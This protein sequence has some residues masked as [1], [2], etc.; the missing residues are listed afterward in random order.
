VTDVFLPLQFEVEVYIFDPDATNDLGNP[1][2]RWVKENKSRLVYGWGPPQASPAKEVSVGDTRYAINTELY[3]PPDFSI[4]HRD[5]I[6]LGDVTFT[7]VGPREDYEHNPF[8]W[9]PGSVVNL[10]AV[11]GEWHAS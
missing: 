4:K 3:V 6:K 10:V 1:V 9:N 5:R 7:V 8:D 2:D 11:E